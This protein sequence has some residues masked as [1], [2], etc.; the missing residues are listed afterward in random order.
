MHATPNLHNTISEPVACPQP[1]PHN[2]C[3]S[4]ALSPL[5]PATVFQGGF[6][7]YNLWLYQNRI[8]HSET[9]D[10]GFVPCLCG[11]ASL[12]T[13]LPHQRNESSKLEDP[14]Q[15]KVSCP[16]WITPYQYQEYPSSFSGSQGHCDMQVEHCDIRAILCLFRGGTTI[17]R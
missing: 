4:S 9:P 12:L 8:T 17:P 2:F 13:S 3:T 16:L 11:R 1:Q 10:S 5:V 7:C 6:T 15:C 14:T